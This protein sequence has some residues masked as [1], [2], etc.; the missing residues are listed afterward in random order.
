MKTFRNWFVLAMLATACSHLGAQA[1]ETWRPSGPQHWTNIVVQ[2]AGGVTYFTHTSKVPVCHR[3]ASGP[4]YGGGTN[5][6]QTINEEQWGG[7]C[8]LCVDCYHMETHV[9]VLG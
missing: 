6:V 1:Q 7:Y 2:T 5:L 9:S 8:A 3:V 4:V